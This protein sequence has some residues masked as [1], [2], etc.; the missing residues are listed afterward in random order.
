MDNYSFFVDK[1]KKMTGVDLALYKEAQMKRRLTSLYEKKGYGDFREFALALE[2]NETL[3]QETLDRMTINVSEFY[4]NYKRWEVLEKTILPL[5]KPAKTLKVW[6]AA[7]STGEEPYTLSMILSRQK[8]LSD[9]QIIATDIDD[10]VLAKAKEGVYQE[11]SLLEV[12][13][14]MKE[15]YFTQDGS[16]FAVKDEIRKNIRFQKHN[17][18]ADPYEKDF[19]II[20]CRNVL[21]YFTEEAKEKIYH[22]FS[23]SLKNK[24][25][26]FVGS[27]E[28]IFNPEKYGFQSTDTFFYQKS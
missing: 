18:L 1:W 8:S 24:G 16:R 15:L 19:D 23:G 11:R 6:S 4:R 22:K 5:L 3:L 12:P 2:K 7:C 14:E 28:Q 27:T 9:Y 10:K 13:K 20:V 26:L 17:L 25:V 21:I